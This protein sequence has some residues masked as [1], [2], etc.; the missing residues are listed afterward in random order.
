VARDY[1]GAYGGQPGH[2]AQPPY[3]GQP[4]PGGPP[5]WT[6]RP[7]PGLAARRRRN[8]VLAIALLVL[9]VAGLL[10]AVAGA[11]NQALPRRFTA[12]QR[13]QITDWEFGQRWRDLPAG[14]IFPASVSYPPPATLADDGSLTLNA[15]RVG[16]ARQASCAAAVDTTAAGVLG[17]DGCAALL[18]ATYVDGTGSYVLT[19]GAAVLPTAAQATAAARSIAGVSGKAGLGSTVH[20]VQFKDTPA[21]GFSAQRRQLSGVVAAGTYVVLYTVGYADDRPREPVAADDSYTA[22]EM[23]SAGKGVARAVLAVLAAPVP[24]AKCPGAPGC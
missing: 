14:T 18:R 2:G 1:G 4:G 21:A 17:R 20:T 15:R 8:R 7:D 9:G 13:Q 12:V 23:N 24:A 5:E 22:V 11:V 6:A 3:P 19:V 10:V 16:V